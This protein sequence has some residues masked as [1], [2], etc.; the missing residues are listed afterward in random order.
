MATHLNKDGK[1]V[2][3]EAESTVKKAKEMHTERLA[4]SSL[5]AISL[6]HWCSIG[7]FCF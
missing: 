7:V 2:D 6:Q 1:Y 4:T 3:E 5:D